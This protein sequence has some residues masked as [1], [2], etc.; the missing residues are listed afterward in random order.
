MQYLFFIFKY[1]KRIM[2]SSNNTITIVIELKGDKFKVL[3]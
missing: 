3:D 2:K 1:Q